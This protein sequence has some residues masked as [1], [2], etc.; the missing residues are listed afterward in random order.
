MDF[1]N[2]DLSR[3]F[4]DL[5]HGNWFQITEVDLLWF[6]GFPDDRRRSEPPHVVQVRVYDARMSSTCMC[7]ARMQLVHAAAFVLPCHASLSRALPQ[8]A[9]MLVSSSSM[10]LA[11]CVTFKYVS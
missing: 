1:G 3:H 10:V 4:I 8:A 9:V 11:D 2:I 5:P 6:P 7:L